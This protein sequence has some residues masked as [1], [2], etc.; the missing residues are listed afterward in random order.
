[1]TDDSSRHHA[2][3]VEQFT[4]Q[5][6]PF[7]ELATHS[8]EDAFRMLLEA[9]APQWDDD[10]LDVACGPGLVAFYLAPHV[11][12]VTGADLTPAMLEQAQRMQAEKGLANLSW[13]A[14]A[15]ESLPFADASFSLVVTR[16]SL[17]HMPAPA[18]AIAEMRRVCRPGGRIVIVDVYTTSAEQDEFFNRIERLRDPSHTR[19]LGLKELQSLA[20]VAG[21]GEL[22]CSFY[23]LATEMESQLAAS[24]PHP[25]D[26]QKWRDLLRDD[27]GRNRTG[28]QPYLDGGTIRFS[29]PC[30][31][32]S[33][34]R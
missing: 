9:A 8:S 28:L 5:A 12:H 7:A 29:F 32:L 2:L 6:R 24:F 25:G 34:R 23:R 4:Q 31:V 20:T 21:I 30:V 16:Y 10:V 1:M 22:Q 13:Q 33:G 19:A 18:A 27:V 14:A 15:A 17:H 11:R 26:D 3:I